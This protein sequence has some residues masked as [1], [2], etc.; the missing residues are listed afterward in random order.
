LDSRRRS[1]AGLSTPLV[2]YLKF[3][4]KEERVGR[5]RD[6]LIARLV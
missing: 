5:E 3:V 4:L 6:R 2:A 1:S